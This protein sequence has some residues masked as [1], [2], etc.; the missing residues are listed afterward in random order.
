[1][2]ISTTSYFSNSIVGVPN[3]AGEL[4]D[5]YSKSSTPKFAL[6]TKFERQ[7]G[8]VFRYA[9]FAAATSAGHI[10]ASISTD[11]SFVMM[12]SGAV[13]PSSTY[14][15]PNEQPGVYP[16]AVGSRYIVTGGS[17]CPNLLAGVVALSAT[18]NQFAGS[19][20]T[21]VSSNVAGAQ[22]YTYRVRSNTV[23]GTPA[24]GLTRFELYDPLVTAVSTNTTISIAGSKYNDLAAAFMTNGT[25]IA[26]VVPIVQAATYYGWVQTKGIAGVQLDSTA[27]T[28]SNGYWISLSTGIA[29]A[30]ATQV[31]ITTGAA[32]NGVAFWTPL[33][34]TL[35][36]AT[37]GSYA[38]IVDLCIE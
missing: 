23:T 37:S 30:G 22:G 20:L 11:T 19:Y 31:T 13:A 21:I 2:A 6:G 32:G 35:V 14:Q 34:G 15:M 8:A 3:I 5:V 7:D 29:G 38:G 18:A 9:Y 25:I 28:G 12:T 33:V 24:T 26:G 4:V 17:G 10:V 16:G 1:M 27:S 36:A